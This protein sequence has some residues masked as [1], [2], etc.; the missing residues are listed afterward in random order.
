MELY[1]HI[2]FCVKKCNYCDFLSFPMDEAGK[3]AYHRALLRDIRE[4]SAVYKNQEISSIFFG[5]GTPSLLEGEK[6][7][8]LLEAICRAFL[9][10]EDCEITMEC[11]PGTVTQEKLCAYKRAGVN[12]LS[13]GIQSACDR[14]LSLL[15]RVHTWRDAK[16]AFLMARQAGFSNLG[17]DVMMA[18]PGQSLEEYE[19]TLKQVLSLKP[20][21]ISAY[22]LIVEEGT[23]FARWYEKEPEAFPDEETSCRMYKKTVEM[24][25]KAGYRQYEISNYAK[26]GFVCR[27]NYGYWSN[28]PY[29]GIGL[30]AGSYVGL[31]RF[32]NTTDWTSYLAKNTTEET[33]VLTNEEQQEEFFFLGMRRVE[34]ISQKEF[35]ARFPETDFA[36]YK[37]TLLHF[38]T[39]GLVREENGRFSLTVDGMLVSN[40]IFTELGLTAERIQKGGKT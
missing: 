22:D 15:G 11:N 19:E 27:H 13:I 37:N 3:K 40:V 8:E 26:P 34:G 24:L 17:V 28:E 16:E 5:G 7:S 21:H 32:R 38:L 1:L 25:T 23:H 33:A 2:P 39:Q 12:R 20:E 14:A 31:R 29:L 9:V 18:L 10:R 36:P 4:A 30:G 35:A 6:V